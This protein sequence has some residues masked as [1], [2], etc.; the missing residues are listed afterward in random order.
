[1]LKVILNTVVSVNWINDG[2]FVDEAT[3]WGPRLPRSSTCSDI[4]HSQRWG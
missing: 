3:V 1:M 4:C 2:V